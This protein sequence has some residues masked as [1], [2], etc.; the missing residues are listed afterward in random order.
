MARDRLSRLQRHILA[1][2]VAE[3]WGHSIV[4]LWLQAATNYTSRNRKSPVFMHVVAVL[5]LRGRF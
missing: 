5:R 2:L 4:P 3:L 1:W